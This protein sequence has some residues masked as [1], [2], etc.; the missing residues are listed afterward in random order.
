MDDLE[1]RDRRAFLRGMMLTSA[2]LLVPMP[3]RIFVPARA[4]TVADIRAMVDELHRNNAAPDDDYVRTS[5]DA[6]HARYLEG[7]RRMGELYAD[8]I[9][10][11]VD[12]PSIFPRLLTVRD[13]EG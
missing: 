3:A 4:F 11:M 5:N 8:H 6:E 13:V 2:G 12:R 10:R 7:M 1:A 9:A